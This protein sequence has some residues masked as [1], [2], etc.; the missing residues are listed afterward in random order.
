MNIFA[1]WAVLAANIGC[2]VLL[3]VSGAKYKSQ[4]TILT[5]HLSGVVAM[6]HISETNGNPTSLI[7]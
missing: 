3:Y 7:P 6:G 4:F 5:M 1:W 2:L